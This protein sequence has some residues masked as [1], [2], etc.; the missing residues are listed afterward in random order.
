MD[1]VSK[2][3]RRERTMKDITSWTGTNYSATLAFDEVT[4]AARV[5]ALVRANGYAQ[6]FTAWLNTATVS[7]DVMEDDARIVNSI[8]VY[9][10]E[11]R[12]HATELRIIQAASRQFYG[13]LLCEIHEGNFIVY[14]KD[15][16]A[17]VI[18]RWCKTL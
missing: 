18:R 15:T 11:A 7:Q 1:T 17:A 4:G 8:E 6:N 14:P 5:D 2:T 3:Y 10:S 13:C 16:I 12:N 9:E